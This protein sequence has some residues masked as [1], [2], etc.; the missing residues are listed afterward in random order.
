MEH[1]TTPPLL[2][3][4]EQLRAN[5]EQIW[6]V[7]QRTKSRILLDQTAFPAWPLYP[8]LGLYLSG[9][10]AGTAALARQGLR[11]MDRD[12]HGVASGLSPEEFSALLPCCHNITF[13]S[14][15]Q[16][17]QFGPEARAKGVSCALRVTDGRLCRPGIPLDALPEQ[18]PDGINGL[19]LQL[20]DPSA[21]T[22]LAAA[23]DQVEA[24]LGGLLP[25]LF[26]FS[27]GGSFPLTAPAFDLAGLEE[28]LRRFRARWGLLLYLEVGDA[29]G[30]SACAPLP[31]PPEFPF[32]FPEGYP[33]IYVK[34]G[35]GAR[36]FS[37]F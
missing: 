20:S 37:H 7:T 4:L 34:Q 30:R 35:S 36:P 11:Y 17:R 21:P 23:L 24:R 14:W 26:Q 12:S 18:L 28:I 31:H 9:T 25:G 2:I 32:P 6:A 15:D 22:H 29:V 10:T 13:D 5:L 3:D 8:M 33:P 16:W 19:Q 27:V 1:Q